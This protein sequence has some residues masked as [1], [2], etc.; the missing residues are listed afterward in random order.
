[1]KA[2]TAS[3]AILLVRPNR[4]LLMVA[5]PFSKSRMP[6]SVAPQDIPL[7]IVH[8]DA[9]MLAIN[10]PSGMTTQLALGAVE[11]AVVFHLNS[12][13]SQWST[14]TWPWKGDESFEGIVHRLDKGTSGL[15]VIGK[16]PVAARALQAAFRERLVNKTYLAIGVGMPLRRSR[17]SLDA[18]AAANSKASKSSTAKSLVT[19]NKAAELTD[20]RLLARAIKHCGR[21]VEQARALLDT[22]FAAGDE[23]SI[24][25][26][27]AVLS[28]CVRGV[29]RDLSCEQTQATPRSQRLSS[30]RASISDDEG[31]A[32]RK[33]A[34]AVFD[35]MSVRGVTPDALCFQTVLGL[36]SREP[37]LWMEAVQLIGRMESTSGVEPTA[38]CVSS[39]ISACGRAGELEA[40]LSLLDVVLLDGLPDDGSC[41]RAAIRAAERCGAVDTTRALAARLELIGGS[42]IGGATGDQPFSGTIGETFVVNSPIGKLG[43]Y[44]MGLM[45]VVDGGREALS[46]VTPI[47]FDA[48]SQLSV[49]RVVIETGRTHQ[50]RVHMASV[51]GCPLAGDSDYGVNSHQ[52]ASPL[53]TQL[54]SKRPP[55]AR[56]MLHAAELDVPHPITGAVLRLRCKPP[57]DFM[58]LAASIFGDTAHGESEC[59]TSALFTSDM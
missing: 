58:D 19:G 48:E 8:E 7:D 25:C 31:A 28:V 55:V 23:P 57:P 49:N 14:S 51:L 40:A 16:H 1:M 12:T 17:I 54:G 29:S 41:L 3:L 30:R 44:T 6:R 26:Y 50:I 47:A 52:A 39:A 35:S 33:T 45:D 24:L 15:L 21:D 34:L 10:K 59:M 13:S 46:V 11:N 43:K 20:Q 5:K 18:L 37:P 53:G 56:V 36:C 42:G 22:A 32:V 38:H 27:S 4:A 2:L 9:D